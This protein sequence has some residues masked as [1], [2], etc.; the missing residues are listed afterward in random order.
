LL[1]FLIINNGRLAPAFLWLFFFWLFGFFT[2]TE[3]AMI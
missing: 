1:H 2:A 3:Y